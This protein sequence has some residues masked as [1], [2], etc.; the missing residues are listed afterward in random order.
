MSPLDT[1][2]SRWD[3]PLV[4]PSVRPVLDPLFRPAALA[5]RAFERSARDTGRPVRARF[6]LEQ[7]GGAVSAFRDRHAPGGPSGSRREPR[8]ARAHGQACALGAREASGST[9]TLPMRWSRG[10]VR[11]SARA[12]RDGSI[13]PWSASACTTTRSKWWLP[14]IRRRRGPRVRRSAGISRDAASASISAAAIARWRPWST[15]ASSGARRSSGTRTTRPTRSTTGTESWTRS[16]APRRICRASTPSG[17]APPA[18]MWITRCASPRSF[19][20]SRPT[21]S[22]GT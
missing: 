15:A 20:A 1:H 14:P 22:R 4:A 3:L 6:A 17:A 7:K 13:R 10:C 19:A 8:H 18:S 16:S 9:S 12:R 5:R 2:A 21:P 11:T